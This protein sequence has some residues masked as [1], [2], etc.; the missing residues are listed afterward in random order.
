MFNCEPFEVEFDEEGSFAVELDEE[1]SFD[2][3]FSEIQGGGGTPYQDAY[4]ATPS[5]E[6]QV[7]QTQGKTMLHDFIL[8]KIPPNYGLV[9]WDGSK[10]RI[11]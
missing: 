9:T 1:D 5:N 6:E 2:V 10:L 11:S 3:E 4:E 7:L 8:R